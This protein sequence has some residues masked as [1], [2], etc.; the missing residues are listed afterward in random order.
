MSSAKS[1]Q[2]IASVN[3]FAV[4]RIAASILLLWASAPHSRNYYVVLR[5]LVCAIGVY[6]VFRMWQDRE[7]LFAGYFTA[8][9]ILFNPILPITLAIGLSQMG[10]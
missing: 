7:W 3:I 2:N 5:F 1:N 4:A 6:G 8:L 10:E 9:T